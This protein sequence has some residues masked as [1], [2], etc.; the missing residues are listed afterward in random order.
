MKN[1]VTATRIRLMTRLFVVGAAALSLTLIGSTA[2]SGKGSPA[3]AKKAVTVG[4]LLVQTGGGA[5]QGQFISQGAQLAAARLTASKAGPTVKL[6]VQDTQTNAAQAVQAYNYFVNAKGMKA[7]VGGISTG[8]GLAI[9]PLA[10]SNKVVVLAPGISGLTFTTV[11]GYTFRTWAVG[12]YMS[13]KTAEYLVKN[14]GYR[15]AAYLAE[16]SEQYRAVSSGIE[17]VFKKA[18]GGLTTE[19]VDPT[20]TNFLPQ[21][22]KLLAT[23]PDVL[24]IDFVSPATIGNAVKQARQLGW[25]GPILS[26]NNV[27]NPAFFAAAGDAADGVIFSIP[28]DPSNYKPFKQFVAAFQKKYGQP[29]DAI[30]ASAYDDVQLIAK[31]IAAVGNNGPKIRAW[32]LKLK[33]Y[34]GVSGVITFKNDGNLVRKPLDI[35]VFTF[36]RLAVVSH[37]P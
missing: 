13:E 15:T 6:N 23:K 12:A 26:S 20:Q 16:D 33:N 5:P 37:V 27:T 18:G 19:F 29:P 3:S 35:K 36:G 28:A 4:L 1:G 10:N 11:G 14:H 22:A 2:A 9:Q 24:A 7:L 17:G 21:L 30:A 25:D 31:A 32:L 8:E 34:Q